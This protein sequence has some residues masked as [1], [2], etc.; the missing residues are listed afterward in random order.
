M[1]SQPQPTEQLPFF[2]YGTL[3]PKQPNY[4]LL[5]DFVISLEPAILPNGRLHDFGHYPMLIEGDERVVQ[6]MVV[7]VS[8]EAYDTVLQ[9]LDVLE[10][11]DPAN[12]ASSFYLRVVRTVE[13]GNGRC[14]S[15]WVYVGRSETVKDLPI[16]PN[17]DWAKHIAHK[18]QDSNRWWKDI[19][20]V[21]HLYDDLA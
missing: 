16:V 4:Y 7:T 2:V 15:A 17:G 20:S 5:D 13:L 14:E 10:G 12:V 9:Q 8:P 1:R 21:S 11:Y 6:G 19:D 3:L 18:L